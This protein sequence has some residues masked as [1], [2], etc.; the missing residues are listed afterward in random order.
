MKQMDTM[1]FQHS[2]TMDDIKNRLNCIE[3]GAFSESG[4]SGLSGLPGL[5]GGLPESSGL[6]LDQI[7]PALMSDN[8]FVSGI[9]DNIMTNSNL[10]EIIEQIDTIQSETREL[11]ELL[12]AQQKTINEMNIM[13]LKLISQSLVPAAAPIPAAALIPAAPIPAAPIPASFV[14]AALVPAALAPAALVPAA[15]VPAVAENEREED[16]VVGVMGDT[17]VGDAVVG[18]A[19][20]VVEDAGGARAD[21]TNNIQLD[22]MDV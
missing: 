21:D 13:L 7:K 19:D 14:P 1:L 10:S 9:V 4:L 6:D 15:L 5:S 16:A 8:D 11:R 22:V 17:V 2:Q 18:D 12:H 20:T 3:S